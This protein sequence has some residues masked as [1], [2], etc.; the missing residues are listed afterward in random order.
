VNVI[1][2]G[3][4]HKNKHHLEEVDEK[5][6]DVTSKGIPVITEKDGEIK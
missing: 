2:E 6:E 5:F 3:A 4:L 1:P